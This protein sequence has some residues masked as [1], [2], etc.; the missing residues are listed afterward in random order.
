MT[1]ELRYRI[2]IASIRNRGLDVHW[3]DGHRS[4]YHPMWLRHQCE[5]NDCGTSLDG[6]RGIRIHHIAEN[7]A[8][9]GVTLTA[10]EV[11]IAWSAPVLPRNNLRARC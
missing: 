1:N 2:D 5:C 3:A 7:I 8:V 11:N 10:S 4:R 6:V 9:S